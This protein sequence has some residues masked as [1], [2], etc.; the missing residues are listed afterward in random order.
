[1]NIRIARNNDFST[2]AG[3]HETSIATGFLSKLGRKFLKELYSSISKQPGTQIF[4]ADSNDRIYGFVAATI[5]IHGLYKRVVLQ[6]GYRF[7]LILLKFKFDLRVIRMLSETFFYG[8]KKKSDGNSN[9]IPSELLSISVDEKARGEG[10][11]KKLVN[12]LESFFRSSGVKVYKVV[13]F[14]EDK[15]ANNFYGSCDFKLNRQFVHHGNIMNEYTKE[16]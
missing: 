2:I 4:V 16:I 12:E 11:G 3:L 7:A 15:I 10:I 6:N 1:M 14:S 9:E 13:T 5:N 8:F